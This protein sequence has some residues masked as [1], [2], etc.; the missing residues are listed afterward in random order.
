[1]NGLD[2]HD[3]LTEIDDS[4]IK[5]ADQVLTSSPVF[6]QTNATQ[7]FR[8]RKSRRNAFCVAL[9]AACV[10]V[11]LAG[12][13]YAATKASRGKAFLELIGTDGN[14][15]DISSGF[16]PIGEAKQ[17]GALEITLVDIIGDKETIYAELST[18]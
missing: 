15:E 9:I 4:F 8:G 17:L 12:T 7:G 1:M 16:V 2:L 5:E 13:V 6:E 14:E 10:V 18:N 3:V 11:L